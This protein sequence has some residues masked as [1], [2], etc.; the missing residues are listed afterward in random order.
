MVRAREGVEGEIKSITESYELEW[1]AV[2]YNENTTQI[3]QSSTN[4]FKDNITRNRRG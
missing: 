4:T 1:A 2:P 3:Q